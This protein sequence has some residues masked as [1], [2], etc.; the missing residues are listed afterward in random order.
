MNWPEALLALLISHATG[1]VL[2]QTEW[3]AQT[4]PG[5]L[6][7]ALGRRALARHVATYTSAFVPALAWIGKHRGAGR[8]TTVGALVAIPHLVIDDGRF[9]RAW[10]R[11][12]KRASEPT[13][14][15]LIAVDQSFHVLSLLG[16]A[17]VAAS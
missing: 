10:S 8:A 3:Q 14:A 17:L 13:P 5:G 12:I 9:V 6:G 15:L 16:A 4:K 11:G 7:D 2:L 1:D